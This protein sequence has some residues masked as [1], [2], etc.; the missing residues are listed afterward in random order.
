MKK[1]LK[2]SEAIRSVGGAVIEL[3]SAKLKSRL[4]DVERGDILNEA[5]LQIERHAKIAEGTATALDR[6]WVKGH[7]PDPVEVRAQAI[8][9]GQGV[10][11]AQ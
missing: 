4:S 5:A 2:P 9:F 8:L 1:K 6:A 7:S 10:S 11:N 3:L